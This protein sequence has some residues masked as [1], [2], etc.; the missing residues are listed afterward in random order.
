MI[1]TKKERK[2]KST[3]V[4]NR[5]LMESLQAMDPT[6]IP[7]LPQTVLTK[8]ISEEAAPV[9]LSCWRKRM[10]VEQGRRLLLIKEMGRKDRKKS[11]GAM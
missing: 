9:S 5:P 8:L 6:S 3:V 10:A 2:L 11:S 4:N 7:M 1:Q